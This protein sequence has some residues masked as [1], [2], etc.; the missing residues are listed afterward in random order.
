MQPADSPA[1]CSGYGAL[2]LQGIKCWGC[3]ADHLLPCSAE[4]KIM[5]LYLHFSIH[6]H[7]VVPN[8]LNPWIALPFHQQINVTG[9]SHSPYMG[10]IGKFSVVGNLYMILAF[11]SGH[12]PSP[13]ES[14]R[15]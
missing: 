5:E 7:I 14:I 15:Y 8:L 13:S 6:L 2:F 1:L 4:A 10:G 3:E 9:K 11:Y 12:F